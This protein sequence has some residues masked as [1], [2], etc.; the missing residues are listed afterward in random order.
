M[1]TMDDKRYTD[2]LKVEA[3]QQLTE[4]GDSVHDVLHGI[5]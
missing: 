2:E 1:D 5:C 4:H 3:V